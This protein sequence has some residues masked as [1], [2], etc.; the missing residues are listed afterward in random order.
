MI[1]R[2]LDPEEFVKLT[3][4]INAL[5]VDENVNAGHF[6]LEH[7]Y[8][9]IKK[10]FANKFLLAWDVFVWANE[11]NG[12]Y[13]AVIIFINDKS[14]KFNTTIFTE[15]LWLSKNPKVGFKLLKMAVQFARDKEF[16]YILMSSVDKHPKSY[17]VRKIYQ[18]LGF[19]K[20]TEN[21]I[22]KL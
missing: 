8:E 7:D 6:L 21:Y 5:F 20:D 4:D 11:N 16:K 22:A 18:K 9:S 1:K 14:V 2:I 19:I 17:K 10:A 13:D 15:F 12:K 3:D